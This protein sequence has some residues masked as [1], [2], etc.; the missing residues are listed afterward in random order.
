MSPGIKVK[1]KNPS[2][3]KHLLDVCGAITEIDSSLVSLSLLSQDRTFSII[4]PLMN[5]ALSYLSKS[6]IQINIPEGVLELKIVLSILCEADI[7]NL[8]NINP[9]NEQSDQQAE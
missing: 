5:S 9:F 3:T 2:C 4:S 1:L 6:Q 8:C 7:Y